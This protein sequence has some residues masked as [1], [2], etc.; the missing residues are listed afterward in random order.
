VIQISTP[1]P[2]L[3]SPLTW[4]LNQYILYQDKSQVSRNS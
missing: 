1:V 3:K 2:Y 4:G